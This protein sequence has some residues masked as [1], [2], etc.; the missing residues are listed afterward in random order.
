MKDAQ[1]SPD[2]YTEVTPRDFGQAQPCPTGQKHRFRVRRL[3]VHW[4]EIEDV[5]FHFDSAVMMPDAESEDEPGTVDEDRITGLSV[6]R[7]AYMYAADN[8]DQKEREDGI[9]ERPGGPRPA[10]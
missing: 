8:S 4:I 9:G 1:Q 6:I 5:L 7:V 10:P 2:G 3:L